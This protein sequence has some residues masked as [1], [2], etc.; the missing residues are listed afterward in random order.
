MIGQSPSMRGVKMKKQLIG[1]TALVS[2][3]LLAG[4]AVH[5]DAMAADPL[6]L[7]IGGYYQVSLELRNE[8]DDTG[9]PGHNI[10]EFSV[11]DDGEIQ[12]TASTTLD[13]GIGVKARI[14]YEGFNAGGGNTVVDERWVEFSGTF[15]KLVIGSN[16][17]A[18]KEMQYQAPAG[19]YQMGVNTATFAIP[20]VGGNAIGGYPT[21]FVGPSGDSQKI[22]Y[23][24]PRFS[25]FQ[26]GLS[27]SPDDRVHENQDGGSINDDEPGRQKDIF[28]IGVNFVDSFGGVDIAVAG[29]YDRGDL[30]KDPLTGTTTTKTT[31][32]GVTAVGGVGVVV[33]NTN[34]NAAPGNQGD[35]EEVWTAGLT[36]GF[37]GFAV[38][39][40]YVHTNNGAQ[41]ADQDTWDAGVSYSNGPLTV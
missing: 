37:A 40:S 10:Q 12:F 41:S 33:T 6:E 18:A 31:T 39:G 24:S 27:Y 15:G 25:G 3:G 1:T 16:D 4:A 35:D 17:D 22:I 8:D 11:L 23:F 19:S 20:A 9:E 14:E 7:S 34:I 28:S 36:V 32:I 26:L 30:Q 2:A 21:T 5:Q 38:G 13:N 29:G